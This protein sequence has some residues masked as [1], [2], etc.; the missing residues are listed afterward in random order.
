MSR[1]V[2]LYCRI[3]H[4]EELVRERSLDTPGA[5]LLNWLYICTR[6]A[7]LM[8]PTL[9]VWSIVAAAI[10]Q[11]L[12]STFENNLLGVVIASVAGMLL[13][14]STWTEIPVAQ[15][16]IDAGLYGPA[17]TLLIVLPPVSLPCLL[18]LAGTIGRIWVV[19]LLSL[20]VV[21]A[22]IAAGMIFL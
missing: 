19:A 15:Q 18:L 12:P 14:I 20:A 8:V 4:L 13:M 6:V 11:A 3:F 16:M 1:W 2:D 22:G 7:L 21:V 9:L 10:I 17:A 5:F